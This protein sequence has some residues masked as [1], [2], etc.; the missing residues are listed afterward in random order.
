MLRFIKNSF[1]AVT[2][3]F[4]LTMIIISPSMMTTISFA[5]LFSITLLMIITFN[6]NNDG[7]H[8]Q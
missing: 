3:L 6:S 7:K 2:L 1:Y 4:L 8:N 5:A